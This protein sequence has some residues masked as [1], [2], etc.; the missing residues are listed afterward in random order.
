MKLN[1]NR[2]EIALRVLEEL[3]NI[4]FGVDV[5]PNHKLTALRML[6][7]FLSLDEPEKEES[8]DVFIVDDMFDFPDSPRQNTSRQNTSRSDA[9]RQNAPRSDAPRPFYENAASRRDASRQDAP[10]RGGG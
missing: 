1:I 7:K 9:S 10:R 3:Q 4:A 6:I 8:D 5:K 2:E